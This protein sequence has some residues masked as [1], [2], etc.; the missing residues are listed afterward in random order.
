M[1][2]RCNQITFY[3]DDCDEKIINRITKSTGMSFGEYMRNQ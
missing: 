2:K 3:I 1:R